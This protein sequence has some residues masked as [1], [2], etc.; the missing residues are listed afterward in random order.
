[1]T[2]VAEHRRR[3]VQRTTR[4]ERHPRVEGIV[5]VGSGAVHRVRPG[6]TTCRQVAPPSRLTPATSP[7]NRSCIQTATTLAGL[8]GLTATLGSTSPLGR[9]S[10]SS[11]GGSHRMGL[12][13]TPAPTDRCLT[14]LLPRW[15]QA[16]PA[17]PR[18]QC[19]KRM[20]R[21]LPPH[22]IRVWGRMILAAGCATVVRPR[23]AVGLS[24]AWSRAAMRRVGRG[25]PTTVVGC[26]R[27][28]E[29]AGRGRR[30]CAT[31]VSR[32]S[33]KPPAHDRTR[34]VVVAVRSGQAPRRR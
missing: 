5:E 18:R 30:A 14:I 26:L 4:P 8:V 34:L 16:R 33:S 22:L 20:R 2:G 23:A 19:R 28:A 10:S 21:M 32:A 13:P 12:G 29:Q 9:N 17:G 1:M 27:D 6:R 15:V 31:H 11:A 24:P 3:Q 7:R 25:M